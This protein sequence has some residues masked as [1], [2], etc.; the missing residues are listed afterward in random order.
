MKWKDKDIDKLY[1]DSAERLS[2]E[3]KGSYWD[4]FEKTLPV[5][6]SANTPDETPLTDA[7]IDGMYASSAAGLSFDY[8]KD[9]W[10]E[11]EES[12]PTP[13][14]KA[15][16]T[17]AE[18]DAMYASSAAALSFA[19]NKNY[20]AQFEQT[21]PDP[22]KS[23]QLSDTEIDAMYAASAAGL[24]FDYSRQ[25][26]KDF[27]EKFGSAGGF[28][29]ADDAVL[30]DQEIDGMYQES[31]KDLSFEYK[32]T[33][34]DEFAALWRRKRRPDFLWF[35][36]AYTFVG[37]IG[38]MMFVNNGTVG[39]FERLLSDNETSQSTKSNQSVNKSNSSANKN[40]NNSDA[41]N[42]EV[43]N[44]SNGSV[45]SNGTLNGSGNGISTPTTGGSGEPVINH[46]SLA[47]G[48]HMDRLTPKEPIF[49]TSGAELANTGN[50]LTYGGGIDPTD[51]NNPSDPNDPRLT[52][53][54][55]I[56]GA[57]VLGT[58][59]ESDNTASSNSDAL[60]LLSYRDLESIISPFSPQIKGPFDM[61]NYS[62]S[63]WY[64]QGLG[65]V[66]Q[67]LVTP[68]EHVSN[69]IGLG[70]GLELN[71]RNFTFTLGFNG[72]VENHNDLILTRVAKVYSFGSEVHKH[73]IDYKQM[74]TLEGLVGV[75]YN[76]TR[77]R[78]EIGVRPSFVVN[79]RVRIENVSE[80]AGANA[81]DED[82]SYEARDQYGMME[83]ISRWGVK[84]TIG[85]S[86]KISPIWTI[87]GNFGVELMPSINEDFINGVNNTLPLDGQIYLR[88]TFSFTR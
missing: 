9:Y 77:H 80:I 39:E 22:A 78:V 41:K 54:P 10:A 67:S 37:A 12:L 55:G 57:V 61:P 8:K 25:Y 29:S 2:F 14:T 38:L 1:S 20:W 56:P 30:A 11:F 64:A 82:D 16:L 47:G 84:P 45:Q 46:G 52:L 36:T 53:E 6:D 34:W 85:Y 74:Y 79:T 48:T 60:N 18:I 70:L 86:F 42:F 33:Y 71:K 40:S 44:K 13:N 81:S 62:Y 69:S 27:N 58:I 51:P 5:N 49:I 7:E 76:F 17:D 21:L 26:W 19:Y 23:P 24:S 50:P 32:Q 4:E 43:D 65:G 68:S 66:S 28:Q 73:K 87:G 31:A 59:A 88:R 83:G 35:A 3:Y 63:R 72:L 75:G 15:P